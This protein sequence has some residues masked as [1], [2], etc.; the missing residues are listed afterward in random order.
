MTFR[1]L[2]GLKSVRKDGEIA[3]KRRKRLMLV[4]CTIVEADSK[5]QKQRP[6]GMLPTLAYISR[7][8]VLELKTLIETKKTQW[9]MNFD[10]YRIDYHCR[11]IEIKNYKMTFITF[12]VFY[13]FYCSLC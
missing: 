12:L 2:V 10:K 3:D 11:V 4:L 13:S 9:K 8:Y 5:N 7:G 6:D 1:I